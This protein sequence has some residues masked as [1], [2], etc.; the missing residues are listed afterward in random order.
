MTGNRRERWETLRNL[1]LE[2]V[3]EAL[4]Y[5][6][7]RVDASRWKRPG[8]T[9]S[10]NGCKFF[11]HRDGRGGG[12][13]ID[14]VMHAEGRRFNDAVRFLEGLAPAA[15]VPSVVAAG[16]PKELRLPP[17]CEAAWP[18]VRN[19]LLQ[20]RKLPAGL[21]EACRRQGILHADLRRNSVVCLVISS[22]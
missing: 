18:T 6:R 11:D 20:S 14:L 15:V 12:G 19:Y 1:P 8:S 16:G 10:V 7:D 9:L 17:P 2:T 21:V 3:A 4:G 13:A 5:A 22:Q